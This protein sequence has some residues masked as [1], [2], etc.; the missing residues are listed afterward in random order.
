MVTIARASRYALGPSPWSWTDEVASLACVA[1]FSEGAC[2]ARVSMFGCSEYVLI[3]RHAISERF[4]IRIFRGGD[5]DISR[6]VPSSTAGN[7]E[8]SFVGCRA[9]SQCP[10]HK[11]CC[12]YWC[13]VLRERHPRVCIGYSA[14][15]G[16]TNIL[17]KAVL[18][19]LRSSSITPGN[20]FESRSYHAT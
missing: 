4:A 3:S 20:W 13:T 2:S 19:K 5:E 11:Q 1:S 18:S 17:L 14:Q 6:G 9:W 8:L 16:L 15:L 10:P 7:V 12:R